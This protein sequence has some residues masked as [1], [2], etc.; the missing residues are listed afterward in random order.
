MFNIRA[1]FINR[2][3]AVGIEHRLDV[4]PRE[5]VQ[6]RQI[7]RGDQPTVEFRD[8]LQTWLPIN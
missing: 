8:L 4:A 3:V 1:K 5:I 2:R 7:A 6:R